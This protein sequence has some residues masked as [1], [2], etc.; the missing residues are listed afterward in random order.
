MMKYIFPL[1][2]FLVL[3][4]IDADTAKRA[5]SQTDVYMW[6][7]IFLAL[8]LG[9]LLLIVNLFP[10][11]EAYKAYELRMQNLRKNPQATKFPEKENALQ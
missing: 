1:F 3:T 9:S 10:K 6:G 4:A 11:G 7:G 5:T 2:F 8:S